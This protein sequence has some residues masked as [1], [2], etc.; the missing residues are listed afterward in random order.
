MH[1]PLTCHH[2]QQLFCRGH[3]TEWQQTVSDGCANVSRLFPNRTANASFPCGNLCDNFHNDGV[4]KYW[5]AR[6]ADTC[7]VC[8]D[9][10]A[11]FKKR[12][13]ALTSRA[14]RSLQAIVRQLEPIT[15]K[16]APQM[17]ELL[18]SD[19]LSGY[20]RG[21]AAFAQAMPQRRGATLKEAGG[22]PSDTSL[23]PA[24]AAEG[25]AAP[26]ASGS[27]AEVTAPGDEHEEQDAAAAAAET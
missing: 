8:M 9:D 7:A 2:R 13:A 26:A 18:G 23:A 5:Y 4:T 20:S 21:S 22:Q 10:D 12:V 11:Q 16:K 27:A 25:A 15:C 3:A 1:T 6:H 24:A 17:L 14:F 19:S